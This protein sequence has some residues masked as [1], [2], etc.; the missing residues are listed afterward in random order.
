MYGASKISIRKVSGAILK[1]EDGRWMLD[2]GI[3]GGMDG[4]MDAVGE[5]CFCELNAQAPVAKANFKTIP[6]LK[7]TNK[8]PS[9]LQEDYFNIYSFLH[10]TYQ[11]CHPSQRKKPP[12]IFHSGAKYTFCL[13]HI[14]S[15]SNRRT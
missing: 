9:L 6:I 8:S 15:P 1:V 11:P 14:T 10:P 7:Y 4:E 2:G 13:Y 12:Q 5:L 3:D